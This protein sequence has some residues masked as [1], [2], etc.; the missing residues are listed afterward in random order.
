MMGKSVQKNKKEKEAYECIKNE[1][2]NTMFFIYGD[3]Y[4][5]YK[6]IFLSCLIFCS[7]FCSFFAYIALCVAI[8]FT[9]TETKMKSVYYLIFL[10]P[11]YNVFRYSTDQMYFSAWIAMVLVLV[12]LIRLIN[13]LCKKKKRI[14]WIISVSY[15][16]FIIYLFLQKGTFN[17]S[18]LLPIML[19]LAVT[20]VLF[21]YWDEINFKNLTLFLF[22]G[23]LVSVVFS[24]FI[25]ICPRLSM[26]VQR[27]GGDES[28]NF[29]YQGLSRDPNYYAL[30]IL[31]C[32]SSFT[33]LYFNKKINW[34][35]YP[36]FVILS[37][38]GIITASKSFL[39]TFVVFVIL[40]F[41]CL[42]VSLI[43]SKKKTRRSIVITV[44]LM[45][46]SVLLPFGIC[47]KNINFL[48]ER[49]INPN[50]FGVIDFS[51]NNK[52]DINN[53]NEWI[54]NIDGNLSD[55]TMSKNEEVINSFTTGRS[56]IW[57]EYLKDYLSSP[58]KILFGV[59]MGSSYLGPNGGVAIHNTIIQCLYFWGLFGCLLFIAVILIYIWQLNKFKDIKLINLLIPVF[60]VLVMMCSLDNLF[61]YRSY[62]LIIFFMYSLFETN[63]DEE[64]LI[65]DTAGIE[66]GETTML[67]IIVP[68]YNIEQYVERCVMSIIKNLK[69]VNYELILIDDGST[70][71]SGTILDN[72]KNISNRIIVKHKS[73]G[74]VSSARNLGIEISC[75]K[76]L[77]FIDGDDLVDENI[78]AVGNL[79]KEE[80]DLSIF[81]YTIE[82]YNKNKVVRIVQKNQILKS[83][84]Q[85]FFEFV[86]FSCSNNPWGKLFKR[87]IIVKNNIKFENF[88][89]AEDMLFVSMYLRYVKE[90]NL[91]TIDYY[92]Y[93]IRQGSAM[94]A[95][96]LQKVKDQINACKKA[97]DY[98]NKGVTTYEFKECIRRFVSRTIFSTFKLY[99]HAQTKADKEEIY[100]MLSENKTLFKE[101]SSLKTK[102]LKC[103]I[104]I[105]GLKN[106]L[107]ITDLLF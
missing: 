86:T 34:F 95:V 89:I 14:N 84:S 90:L 59:G 16:I 6:C 27:F 30:E 75:G 51:E 103:L 31:L 17:L 94:T 93:I 19:V 56:Q 43:K 21:Y 10:L 1:F 29:R 25:D 91:S 52:S 8:I 65:N 104:I 60:A 92:H 99:C 81:N 78:D 77:M 72:L 50:Y 64:S 38:L 13:D 55:Y 68:V 80:Y 24:L 88:R 7:F 107:I 5:F 28:V 32:L 100:K 74:G 15:L 9:I 76:Y 98:C 23:I 18:R 70:D 97:I 39:I 4:V 46:I 58:R 63:M 66:D 36:V 69:S 53:S 87:D 11:F 54:E 83:G 101:T 47:Y 96:S 106:A 42:F 26:F 41:I 79:L 3:K 35:Y 40:L 67:S 82:R 12:T 62:I 105:L 20:Y 22:Y 73:N 57:K 49:I 48:I 2:I 102:L 33:C 44:I 85:E 37:S 71:N 45:I 61:S